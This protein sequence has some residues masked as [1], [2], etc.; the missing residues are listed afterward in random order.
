M[1]LGQGRLCLLSLL[2]EARDLRLPHSHTLS[3]ICSFMSPS[4]F[5]CPNHHVSFDELREI[6]RYRH[7]TTDFDALVVSLD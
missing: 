6:M 7:K 4:G 3:N 1:V 2:S 5:A